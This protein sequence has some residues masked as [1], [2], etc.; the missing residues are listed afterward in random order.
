VANDA[1]LSA[2]ESGVQSGLARIEEAASGSAAANGWTLHLGIDEY[3]NDPLLRAV[4][5]QTAWGANTPVE[6]I[7]ATSVTDGAGAAYTGTKD[8]VLRFDAAELPP[9]DA[10]HGFWSLT[11]YGPDHFFVENALDRYAIGDR[12][13]GLTYGADGSLELYIQNAAPSGLEGNWLPSPLGAFTLILRFYLP[14]ETVLSGTYEF[15][16]VNAR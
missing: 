13:P 6:A 8:Y 7:Y 14:S 10:V 16:A 2:L 15:P 12:T 9:V 5:A 11:L 3:E 1:V 4:I